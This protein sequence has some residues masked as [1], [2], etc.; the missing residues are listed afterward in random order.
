[1]SDP[2]DDRFSEDEALSLLTNRI[3]LDYISLQVDA[4]RLPVEDAKQ[5]VGFSANE[6]KRGAP[7]LS[8]KVDFFADVIKRRFDETPYREGAEG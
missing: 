3:L 6:V 7:W 1:M 5:L 2:L 8:E 4:G